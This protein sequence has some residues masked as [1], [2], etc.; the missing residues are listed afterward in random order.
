MFCGTTIEELIKAV[1]RAERE[2]RA[3]A[4]VAVPVRVT[5]YDVNPG[6]VYAMQFTEPTTVIAGVA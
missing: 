2:S 6:F 5:R 4:P 1:E 3:V